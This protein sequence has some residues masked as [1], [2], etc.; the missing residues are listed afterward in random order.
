VIDDERTGALGGVA[1]R[2]AAAG[3]AAREAGQLAVASRSRGDLRAAGA[4][5]AMPGRPMLCVVSLSHRQPSP[6][7]RPQK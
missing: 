7:W 1:V 5:L 6:I 2:A 3:G 4:E